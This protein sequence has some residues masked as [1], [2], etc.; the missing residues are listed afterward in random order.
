MGSS[1]RSIPDIPELEMLFTPTTNKPAS[2]LPEVR[3]IYTSLAHPVNFDF[4]Y[5]IMELGKG[6]AEV[7]DFGDG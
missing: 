6:W 2:T 3:S 1:A 5:G 4:A 7:M